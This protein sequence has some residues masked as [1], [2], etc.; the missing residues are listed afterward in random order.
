[1][2]HL[3]HRHTRNPHTNN[4]NNVFHALIEEACLRSWEKGSASKMETGRVNR[5][6]SDRLAGRRSRNLSNS[7]SL[8]LKYTQ[9]PIEIFIPICIF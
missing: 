6:R 9:T 1:M 8:Q 2:T 3:V 4:K 7:L 5:H